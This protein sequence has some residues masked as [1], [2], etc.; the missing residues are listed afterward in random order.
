M[1]NL[2]L[3]AALSPQSVFDIGSLAKQVTA[4]SIFLLARDGKLSIDDDIRKFV[5]EIPSY[6]A[7]VTIRHLLHHTGGLRDY[8]GLLSLG[9]ARYEDVTTEQDALDALAR[10]TTPAFAPGAKYQYS[11]SG[12]FLLGL[13]V[14]RASGKSLREF[15]RDRIFVPLGMAHTQYNDDHTRVI[16]NRATGYEDRDGGGFRIEMSGFEQN[17]DGGMFTTVEDLLRWDANFFNPVVG[18]RALLE[19]MQTPGK[20]ADGTPIDYAAGLR[21]GS[22]RGL[23]TVGHTGSWAGYRAILYRFPDQKF[24]V[25]I[26]CNRPVDR[27]PIMRRIADLYLGD[28]MEKAPAPAASSASGG[29]AV[30]LSAAQLSRLA[31]AYRDPETE[32]VWFLD[33]ENGKLVADA[34]GSRLAL[35]PVASDRFVPEAG[36]SL[37]VRFAASPPGARP[38]LVATW[39]DEDAETL[40]PI[41][42]WSPTA[43]QLQ[44]FAGSYTSDEI[45]ALFRFAVEN[46]KLVLRHRTIAA[47]PWRPTLTDAFALG[48]LTVT[49][50]RNADGAVDGFRGT[51][52]LMGVRFRRIGV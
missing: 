25:A 46:G 42:A 20:L 34:E 12:Y 33:V 40:E 52:E 4:F 6:G 27:Q 23:R 17:G 51:G 28:L 37:E 30:S 44:A 26:L 19:Q 1:A 49:F 29:P 38:K 47:D 35:R 8:I 32:G 45:P 48:A 24:S 10:Q 5:P 13:V 50:T 22:Y 41:T 2:E 16:P 15:A 36:G 3:G 21:I 39:T 14:K 11:N 31:G 7:P 9:G 18:D 43:S